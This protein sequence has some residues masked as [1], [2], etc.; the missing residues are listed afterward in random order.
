MPIGQSG[1]VNQSQLTKIVDQSIRKL[2]KEAVRVNF[3]IGE[4]TGGDPSIFFRIILTDAASA[5]ATLIDVTNRIESKL[6][7]EIHP[8]ENWGLIPYYS[9]RSKSEQAKRNDPEWKRKTRRKQ[10]SEG[11]FQPHIT[12][13]SSRQLEQA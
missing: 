11:L 13:C 1:L 6:N 12:G 5:E 2:G 4:D 10:S 7:H 9:Y 3:N 8:L